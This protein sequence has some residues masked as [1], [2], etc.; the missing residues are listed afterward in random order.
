MLKSLTT[1]FLSGDSTFQ[2]KLWVEADINDG[3]HKPIKLLIEAERLDDGWTL[4][5]VIK[6]ICNVCAQG[7][8]LGLEMLIK[9]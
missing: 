4:E 1:A 6:V 7:S 9:M 2:L 3:R 5:P 8:N